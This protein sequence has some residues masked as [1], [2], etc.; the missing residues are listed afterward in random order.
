M[1]Y[2]RHCLRLLLLLLL[3]CIFLI[4][5]AITI[6]AVAPTTVFTTENNLKLYGNF[7]YVTSDNGYPLQ[8]LNGSNLWIYMSSESEKCIL[9]ESD[10]NYGIANASQNTIYGYLAN[11]YRVKM[12]FADTLAVY[13]P[14]RINNNTTSYQWAYYR[15]SVVDDNI[16]TD[17]L[18]RSQRSNNLITLII[19]GCICIIIYTIFKRI[20][21][22]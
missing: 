5:S 22:D 20:R 3:S 16:S 1:N 18:Y 19:G 11:G 2:L 10:T 21:R 12:D 15:I 14:H 13:Q 8:S 9:W 7:A 17:L 4:A 6:N